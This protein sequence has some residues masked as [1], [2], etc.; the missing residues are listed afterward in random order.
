M[1]FWEVGRGVKVNIF[2]DFWNLQN[3]CP[4]VLKGNVFRFR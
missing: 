4:F 1:G 3:V 2:S